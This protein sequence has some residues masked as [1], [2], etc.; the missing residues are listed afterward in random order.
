MRKM[1]NWFS[2]FYR[3]FNLLSQIL[4]E[5]VAAHVPLIPEVGSKTALEYACGIGF[6]TLPLASRFKSVTARDLSPVMLATAKE[7]AAGANLT[8]DFKEGNLFE[9]DE[10]D[11]TYDWVFI[12]FAL[13]LF[14]PEH[15]ERIIR[16]LLSIAREGVMII[17]HTHR[18]DFITSLLEWLEGGYYDAYLKMDF[19][20]LA[21][22]CNAREFDRDD[23]EYCTVMTFR[24]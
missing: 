9:I 21:M 4:D 20:E 2:R 18:R 6:L 3:K 1:Y 24:N 16:R 13:H 5:A 11:K 17:D 23:R 14:S 15:Q 7:R 8:V 10:K 19:R 22:R 12:S